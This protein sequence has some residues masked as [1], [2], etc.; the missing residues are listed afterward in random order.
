[1][2]HKVGKAKEWL[3]I[4][5][6]WMLPKSVVKRCFYRVFANATQGEYGDVFPGE[7]LAFD[8]IGRWEE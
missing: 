3:S 7:V 5:V 4:K 8:A 1:M 6:A 2:K